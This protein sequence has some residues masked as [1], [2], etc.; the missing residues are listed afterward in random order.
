MLKC[1]QSQTTSDAHKHIIPSY[2]SCI[3]GAFMTQHTAATTTMV[4]SSR[5]H[6]IP[7]MRFPT[8]HNPLHKPHNK[9]VTTHGSTFPAVRSII[10]GLCTHIRQTLLGR[11]YLRRMA[12]KHLT[13][14]YLIRPLSRGTP[15]WGHLAWDLLYRMRFRNNASY[16]PT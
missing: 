3:C 9:E 12:H 2:D 4:S 14:F 10:L 8:A 11:S 5:R 7:C 13:T 16:N 6:T 15:I 1:S